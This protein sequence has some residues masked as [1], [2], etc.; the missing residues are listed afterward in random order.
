MNMYKNSMQWRLII[1]IDHTNIERIHLAIANVK[2]FV[3][4]GFC[5]K[6]YIHHYMQLKFSTSM[7][8]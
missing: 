1:H 5:T 6:I 2:S 7:T 3:Y 8:Q 4:Y